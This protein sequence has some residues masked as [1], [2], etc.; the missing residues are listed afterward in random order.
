M[1]Q[2]NL[3]SELVAGTIDVAIS[4]GMIDTPDEIARE[5]LCAEP[6]LAGLR[7]GHPLAQHDSV[8]LTDLAD[9]VLGINSEKLF[10]A[11]V[12]SQ[13][14]ALEAA[15]VSPRSVELKDTDI[16]ASRWI[17]QPEVDW[18]LLISSL[19]SGHTDTVF[20][21]VRPTQP[22]PFVLYWTPSRTH[23]PAVRRFVK[24]TLAAESPPGWIE[25]AGVPRRPV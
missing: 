16:T 24:A 21:Q 1:W 19:S 3:I 7:A 23:A 9:E 15:N 22:I 8:S 25:P 18:V 17:D 4:C 20:K 12:L 5:D 10:P 13:R 14:E 2:P 6:L 11:W